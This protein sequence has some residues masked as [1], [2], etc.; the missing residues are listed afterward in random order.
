MLSFV[1]PKNSLLQRLKR[2]TLNKLW[3]A[4]FE[5]HWY[6]NPAKY[7]GLWVLSLVVQVISAMR[8]VYLTAWV[9]QQSPVPIIVVGNVTVGGVGKTPLVTALSDYFKAQG[10][11]VGIVSRG[12]GAR[13]RHFPHRVLLDDKASLVGDEP[14]MLARKTRVPVVIATKRNDAVRYLL[15]HCQVDVILSD[16]GL[17]HYAMGRAVEIVV[18]DGSRGLGNGLCIPAGPLREPPSRL[19]TVDF[20][21]VNSGSWPGAYPMRLQPD[22][23]ISL[24]NGEAV[25]FNQ[26]VM[27]VAAVAGIGNPARFFSTLEGLGLTYSPYQFVDHHAFTPHDLQF[28]EPIVV[29]TEKD[30]VKCCDFATKSMY[31]LSVKA[32]I[33]PDFWVALAQH[34]QLKRLQLT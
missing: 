8:R 15:T 1:K 34:P 13:V 28:K 31:Y 4:R 2:L 12:Y 22:R 33:D 30:A 18:M 11:H 5:Q 26:W 24:M 9:Q 10:L 20:V 21:V 19:K 27:P 17:Q 23:M 3:T 16:D 29:M 14:L 25:S 6:H 7:R 32:Q